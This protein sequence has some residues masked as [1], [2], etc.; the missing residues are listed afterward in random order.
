VQIQSK[1]YLSSGSSVCGDCG[2]KAQIAPFE[3]GFRYGVETYAQCRSGEVTVATQP[4]EYVALAP[5]EQIEAIELLALRTS[6][7]VALRL[8]GAP[9][10]VSTAAIY[11]VAALDGLTLAFGVDG[12]AVNVEFLLGD[13]TANDVARRINSA[14]ALVGVP[15]QPAKV[16]QLGQVEI[17]G[18]RT[19]AQGVLSAFTGTAVAALGLSTWLGGVGKGSDVDVDGLVVM[20]FGRSG[21]VGRVEVSGQATVEVLVAG[22]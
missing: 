17:G 3:L 16:G 21:S 22:A 1:G 9:A 19:G 7:P 20:Q 12:Q 10:S 5:T 11:P 18:V 4:L 13:A 2:S 8:E 15:F 6:G 14:A